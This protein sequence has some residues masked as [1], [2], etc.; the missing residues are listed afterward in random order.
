MSVI[1]ARTDK[2]GE[3]I[4]RVTRS[5][6]VALRRRLPRKL[7]VPMDRLHSNRAG[8]QA[9]VM[10]GRGMDYRESRAYQPG[11]DV[12]R[13]DWRLTARSGRLHTKMFQEERERTL[14]LMVDTNASMHFGTRCRFKS[15][16]AARAAALAAWIGAATSMR[17]GLACFGARRESVHPRAGARGAL[18]VIDA[19][20][21]ASTK[22]AAEAGDAESMSQALLRIV[23]M[24]RSGSQVL[25]VSDG[26]SVEDATRLNLVA[27]RRHAQ[28]RILQ[29]NDALESSLPPSGRYP[30]AW[31]GT[32]RT[33]DLESVAARAR[34]RQDLGR[35]AMQLRQM[36][37][38][39]GLPCQRIDTEQDPLAVVASLLGVTLQGKAP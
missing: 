20:A 8:V 11:D 27:L 12:R 37:R 22:G 6:L 9:S 24:A 26:D 19:L 30:L 39:L 36:A 15:V 3:G 38:E 21:E 4:T 16:Q 25:V 1:L 13:M 35:G 7:A 32:V 10:R 23:R 14:W 28:V 17:V 5:E 18:A 29:V 2:A 34:F 31:H 33:V